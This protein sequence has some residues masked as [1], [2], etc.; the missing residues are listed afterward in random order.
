MSVW[1]ES[2]TSPT[3]THHVCCWTVLRAGCILFTMLWLVFKRIGL[4]LGLLVTGLGNLVGP[5]VLAG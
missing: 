2:L 4:Q 3:A 1:A 5:Y